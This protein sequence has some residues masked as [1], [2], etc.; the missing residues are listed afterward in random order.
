M[1]GGIVLLH[2]AYLLEFCRDR[3][4]KNDICKIII[5]ITTIK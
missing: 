3:L 5:C 2:N 1:T 4:L